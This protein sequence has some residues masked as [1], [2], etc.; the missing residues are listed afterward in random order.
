MA[1]TISLEEGHKAPLRPIY[2][3]SPLEME[4]EAKQQIT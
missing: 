4:E 1:H 3:L 2:E